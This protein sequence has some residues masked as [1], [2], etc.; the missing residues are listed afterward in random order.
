MLL[1]L[2]LLLLHFFLARLSP[3]SPYDEWC[4]VS[5]ADGH[6]CRVSS[7]SI[8]GGGGDIMIPVDDG[9]VGTGDIRCVC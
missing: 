8:G 3:S 5:D 1:L 4:R 9:V 6:S 2:L 7:S